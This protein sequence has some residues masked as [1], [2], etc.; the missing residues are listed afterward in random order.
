M[1][2]VLTPPEIRRPDRHHGDE[3]DHGSGRRPPQ[4]PIDKRTGG[5]G[6][7]DNWDAR[8]QGRRG[9]RERLSQ[10]RMGVFFA[11][12]A[13]L[14]L[15]IALVSAFFV[16]RSSGHFDAYD[17]YI[18][19]WLP[20]ALPSVLWLSTAALVLSSAAAE[21]AR[22]S[23]F[24]EKDI[25]DEWFGLGRPISRR[26]SVWL[27]ITLTSGLLF[28]A[29]QI[30]AWKQLYPQYHRYAANPS[31]HF[32]YIITVAHAAHVAVGIGALIYA[33]IALQRSRQLATRQVVVDATVWYWHAMGALWI[34]LFCLLEFCQ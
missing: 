21:V 1:P 12:F 8:P 19:E 14:M 33:L 9:P 25:M 16:T 26:A 11:L 34:A 6:D 10:V 24:R 4:P 17:H 30:V 27:W 18:N 5:N 31:T 28:V 32:F 23:M 2:S 15:F 29:G 20:T 3:R 7:G 22:H 13:V